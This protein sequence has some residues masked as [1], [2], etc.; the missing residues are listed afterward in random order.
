MFLCVVDP[1][2]MVISSYRTSCHFIVFNLFGD[3][4]SSNN[5]RHV[6][7]VV[8]TIT[9]LFELAGAFLCGVSALLQTV[10]ILMNLT[11]IV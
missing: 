1:L 8:S 9:S 6:G 2:Q 11:G 3:Q 5:G 10:A 7:T 4:S